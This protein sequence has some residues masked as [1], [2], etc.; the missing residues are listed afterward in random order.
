M[1]LLT[2]KKYGIISQNIYHNLD[3]DSLVRLALNNNEGKLNK[4][5][6]LLINT[7]EYTGRAP[8][9]RFI[10]LDDITKDEVNWGKINKPISEEIF[11][12]LFKMLFLSLPICFPISLAE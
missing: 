9:D 8:N 4:T 6:A 12:N 5:G 10:V 3:T 7:G 2:L 11:S 1:A